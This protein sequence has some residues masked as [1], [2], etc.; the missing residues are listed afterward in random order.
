[1]QKDGRQ[2]RSVVVKPTT[3]R[4]SYKEAL[5]GVRTFRPRFNAAAQ[6]KGGWSVELRKE[7]GRKPTVWDRLQP[8]RRSIHDRVGWKVSI[9]SGDTNRP[10]I[11]ERL[12][13]REPSKSSLLL[14]LHSKAENRCFNYFARDHR[15]AQCRDPPALRLVLQIGAQGTPLQKSSGS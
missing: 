1:M 5:V 6:D 8:V 12:G 2:L 7:R 3:H 10:S 15:I 11:K 4:V 9:H 13:G 14:L